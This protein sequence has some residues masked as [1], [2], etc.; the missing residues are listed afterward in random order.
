MNA[1]NDGH[2]P[3]SSLVTLPMEL[4]EAILGEITDLPS[5][6]AAILSHSWFYWVYHD[7][8]KG[9][10]AFNLLPDAL[11]AVESQKCTWPWDRDNVYDILEDY[12]DNKI[13]PWT[14]RDAQEALALHR[15]IGFF[16]DDFA[17]AAL[18]RA[19]TGKG[20]VWVLSPSERDRLVR[21]FYR[22]EILSNLLRHCDRW[23]AK[24][25]QIRFE[26]QLYLHMERYSAWE[27]EQLACVA[28]YLFR[29]LSKR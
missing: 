19:P 8:F 18:S 29:R 23:D 22:F 26:E 2:P 9:I 4:K 15:R 13:P 3:K 28:D 6:K 5:L 25:P 1:K 11:A 12:F 16:V 17:S 14:F 24:A 27:N 21:T 10:I 20:E 7:A